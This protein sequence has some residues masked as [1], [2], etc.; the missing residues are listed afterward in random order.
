MVKEKDSR[1]KYPKVEERNGEIL[2][3]QEKIKGKEG[4]KE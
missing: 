4:H 1:E 2:E 3:E